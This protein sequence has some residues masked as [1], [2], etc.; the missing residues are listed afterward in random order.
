M[1][2]CSQ[3]GREAKWQMWSGAEG[4][5]APQGRINQSGAHITSHAKPDFLWGALFFPEK[6]DNRFSHV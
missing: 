5:I 1:T 2:D 3:K 4:V 6:V